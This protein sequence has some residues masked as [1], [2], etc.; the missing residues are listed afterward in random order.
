MTEPEF[1]SIQQLQLEIGEIF[2]RIIEY[3]L[4]GDDTECEKLQMTIFPMI[5]K[6][7]YNLISSD[8]LAVLRD[9]KIGLIQSI[10][11]LSQEENIDN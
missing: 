6:Y 1:L 9:M 8:A 3:S 10:D 2:N 11:Q 4:S 7:S 5:D